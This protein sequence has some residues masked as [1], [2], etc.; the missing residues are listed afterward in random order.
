MVTET[1]AA[2]ETYGL[3]IDGQWVTPGDTIDVTNAYS[4]VVFARVGKAGPQ[5]VEQALAAA[6]TA[7]ETWKDVPAHE[8]SRILYR[9]SEAL[10]AQRDEIARIITMENGK[11][12]KD[13]RV[14]A[15]RAAQTFRFAA[16]EAR[17]I[18]GETIPME[19][20]PGFEKR[21]AFTLREPIGVV[22]A[23]SPFNFPL[24]LVAHKLAPALAAGNT[25]VLK[26]ATKTPLSALR[27]ARIL[28]DAGLPRGVLNVVVGS[29]PEVGDRLVTDRR[30]AM[31]S[32]TGSGPVGRAIRDKAGMKRI[33]LELG[34]NSANIVHADADLDAAAR[35][36]VR[37]S[38]GTN[39]QS[40]I[41]VQ[42][43]IVHEDVAARFLT[44]FIGH[45]QALVVGDPLDEATDVGPMISE[46]AARQTEQW[47]QEAV[48]QGAKLMLGGRREGAMVWPTVLTDA[49]PEMK[50]VC[51]EAFAPLVALRTYSA[52]DEAIALANDSKFG[53]QAG[54]FT[55]N[56]ALAF[57][58]ARQIHTGGVIIND[59][60][61]FRADHMPYGGVKESG[62]GRE[63]LKYAIEEM[64]ELKLVCFNLP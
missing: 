8:R 3:L 4:G 20:Y 35:A 46:D 9:A 48:A 64:T 60:S 31:V 55:Q 26:P 15:T 45:A 63:G 41:S 30:P 56:V 54:V 21:M 27:L 43:L 12:I 51:E 39:G 13:A 29:G 17:R 16:E 50:V 44:L 25:V 52:F 23:I 33:T 42:R 14:E 40:C 37:G 58:A 10:E 11:A 38:F 7:F 34:N 22:A 18:H 57:Q 49:R 32:F 47:I 5:E 53:L 62:M 19:A 2:P 36:L 28:Q 59:S 6:T 61:A 24:N 1:V